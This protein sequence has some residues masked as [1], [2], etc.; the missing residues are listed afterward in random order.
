MPLMGAGAGAATVDD[1][2]MVTGEKHRQIQTA[3]KKKIKKFEAKVILARS[4]NRI[5]TEV[6]ARLHLRHRTSE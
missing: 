5:S 3:F 4:D 6:Q 2:D 1:D